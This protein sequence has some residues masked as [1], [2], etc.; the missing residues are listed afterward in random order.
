MFLQTTAPL[1]KHPLLDQGSHWDITG[2]FIDS[3]R[4]KKLVEGSWVVSDE[5][6][7]LGIHMTLLQVDTKTAVLERNCTAQLDTLWSEQRQPH[8]LFQG[9]IS[10]V[11]DTLLL[12]LESEK[13]FRSIESLLRVFEKEY[14]VRGVMLKGDQNIGSWMLELL[15]I[16]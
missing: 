1:K 15:R 13:G 16:S 3:D 5:K 6:D 10:M 4:Q 8:G 12:Q 11:E 2:Y 9:Q 7:A 14:E